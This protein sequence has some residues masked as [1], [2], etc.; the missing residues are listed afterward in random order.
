MASAILQNLGSKHP[1]CKNAI[2]KHSPEEHSDETAAKLEARRRRQEILAQFSAKQQSF[3]ASLGES[4]DE[5]EEEEKE[6]KNQKMYPICVVCKEASAPHGPKPVGLVGLCQRSAIPL[7]VKKPPQPHFLSKDRAES[8]PQQEEIAT[9]PLEL[10]QYDQNEL[11]QSF[12]N[13][14]NGASTNNSTI[15]SLLLGFINSFSREIPPPPNQQT[16]PNIPTTE[17]QSTDALYGKLIQGVDDNICVNINTCGHYIHFECLNQFL[18]SRATSAQQMRPTSDEALLNKTEK[19]WFWC[20]ICR[21][22]SN[23]LIPVVPSADDENE[24]MID[25]DELT[26]DSWLTSISK[27]AE[28]A[29]PIS[30]TE[31]A[32]AIVD[33]LRKFAS[34]VYGVAKNILNYVSVDTN[35]LGVFLLRVL[36]FNLANKE[37]ELRGVSGE[38][39]LPLSASLCLSTTP[40][41]S[42]S[43]SSS[44]SSSPI[45]STTGLL[46]S[47]MYKVVF[48]YFKWCTQKIR[49]EKPLQSFLTSIIPSIKFQ[50]SILHFFPSHS[51]TEI[52]RQPLL[53]LEMF[54]V[55]SKWV[56]I[57]NNS[58][59]ITLQEVF[60]MIRVCYTA[61][62]TQALLTLP[63]DEN[64]IG[65]LSTLQQM[66]SRQTLKSNTNSLTT[67]PLN[68]LRT[69]ESKVKALCLPFLRQSALFVY[70]CWRNNMMES[71]A[72]P[73]HS[74]DEF[75]ELR[76]YLRLPNPIELF[77]QQITRSMVQEWLNDLG[78]KPTKEL[79]PIRQFGLIEL[80]SLF[81]DLFH[82][83]IGA[84][85]RNCNKTPVN[86]ALCLICG[87]ILCANDSCCSKDGMG[88]CFRHSIVCGSGS[89]IVI[90][91]QTSLVLLI[92]DERCSCWGSPYLD[93]HKEEDIFLDRGKAL[94]LEDSIYKDLARYIVQHRLDSAILRDNVSAIKSAQKS[95][96]W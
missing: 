32:S 10:A 5:D 38:Q 59:E 23:I 67:T 74:D 62:L 9:L 89:G 75:E 31:P 79:Y 52:R 24:M 82:M 43:S 11:L 55:L 4:F 50:R 70:T 63:T 64:D 44:T 93:V 80:P 87:E 17:S 48:S 18:Q 3:S 84:K 36:A 69:L 76:Q 65:E 73:Q 8:V 30:M 86:P 71:S 91:L 72:N 49:L 51:T 15:L 28:R 83:T 68:T 2:T 16:P 61:V 13:S 46:S 78:G 33:S 6:S 45:S 90:M 40:G 66:M 47:I 54:S 29:A 58:T 41:F 26:F 53:S 35:E 42:S 95:R 56:V 34:K 25:N 7:I 88:E 12:A 96:R 92:R 19:D 94:Y 21:A 57:Y 77:N 20:P 81:Q 14:P 37:I 27:N 60:Y 1:Y 22:L 39:Q 85:C